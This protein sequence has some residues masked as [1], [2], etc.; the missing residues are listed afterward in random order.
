M[1]RLTGLLLSAWE[2]GKALIDADYADGIRLFG[3]GMRA[4]RAELEQLQLRRLRKLL[5]AFSTAGPA[6]EWLNPPTVALQSYADLSTLPVLTRAGLH[7]LATRYGAYYRDRRDI[8]AYATGGSTGEPVRFLISR[9]QRNRAAGLRRK[10]DRLLGWEP[11]LPRLALWR[12]NLHETGRRDDQPARSH[13]GWARRFGSQ[14]FGGFCPT[15]DDYRRFLAAIH[16]LPRCAIWG[17]GSALEDCARFLLG[18]EAAL[19]PGRIAAAWNCGEMMYPPQKDTFRQAFGV[20]PRE[21]YSSR[22]CSGLAAECAAGCLHISPRYIVES[23]DP[24][25]HRQ[26]PSG[27]TGLL[28]V[29]DLF[30]DALPLVRYALGDLGAVEWRQCACGLSSWCLTDLAGRTTTLIEL[31]SGRK[32]STGIF[33]AIAV[34]LPDLHQWTVVRPAANDFEV[35]YK[36]PALAAGRQ[37]EL[38]AML[39]RSLTGARISI[40]R[41]TELPRAPSGKLLPYT[42]LRP[43][44]AADGNQPDN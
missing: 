17:Y 23:V 6:P 13:H 9:R 18:T 31:P 3:A 16:R 19:P 43:D 32:V 15:T 14:Y 27:E 8:S 39:Q 42:D 36:G 35:R 5:H 37:H 26:L 21:L 28:L 20:Q 4:G 25:T 11:G 10:L 40:V 22:E 38:L 29:S 24:E 2:S 34:H 30:N 41:A 12:A 33:A 44:S 7:E 1:S